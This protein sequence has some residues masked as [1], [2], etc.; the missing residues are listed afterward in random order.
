MK[1]LQDLFSTDYGIMSI[2]VIAAVIVGLS[3]AYGVLKSKMAESAQN[4]DK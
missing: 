4:A 2:V 1:A 3:V